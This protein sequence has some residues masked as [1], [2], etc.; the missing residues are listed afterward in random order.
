MRGRTS[1]A[2][3]N[4]RMRRTPTP[5]AMRFTPGTVPVGVG[6]LGDVRAAFSILLLAALAALATAALLASSSG[7]ASTTRPSAYAL[8]ADGDTG[9]RARAAADGTDEARDNAGVD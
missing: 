3:P 9:P 5:S 7:A 6:T 8:V 1:W 4:S 2:T